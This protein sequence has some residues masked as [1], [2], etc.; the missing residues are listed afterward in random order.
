M[1]KLIDFIDNIINSL[2]FHWMR[3]SQGFTRRKMKIMYPGQDHGGLLSYKEVTAIGKHL[4]KTV[5][6]QNRMETMDVYEKMRKDKGEN[7]V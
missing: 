3:Y 7:D 1:N 2:S 5:K 4:Y 6:R